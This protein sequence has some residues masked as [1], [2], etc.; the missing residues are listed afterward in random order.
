MVFSAHKSGFEVNYISYPVSLI[1]LL[2]AERA[3]FS[4]LLSI[5]GMPIADRLK[6]Q[7]PKTPFGHLHAAFSVMLCR[8]ELAESLRY[9]AFVLEFLCGAL[10][11][12]VKIFADW[13]FCQGIQ[14]FVFHENSRARLPCGLVRFYP[15]HRSALCC[16]LGLLTMWR[17]VLAILL[18]IT[19]SY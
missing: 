16:H 18:A 8:R 10:E 11:V 9:A 6:R 15:K 2:T 4:A 5:F 1:Y 19:Q 3:K 7:P 12:F 14:V 17:L 13:G